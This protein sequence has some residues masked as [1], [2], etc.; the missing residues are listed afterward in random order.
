MIVMPNG[1]AECELFEGISCSKLC[2]FVFF[3][4]KVLISMAI[5]DID[6]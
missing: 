6:I 4:E 5:I 2:D 1:Y 3:F